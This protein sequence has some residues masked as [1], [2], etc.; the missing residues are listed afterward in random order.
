M[1]VSVMTKSQRQ[2][3]VLYICLNKNCQVKKFTSIKIIKALTIDQI[4]NTLYPGFSNKHFHN[5]IY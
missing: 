5:I 3:Y 1:F 2:M 4:G